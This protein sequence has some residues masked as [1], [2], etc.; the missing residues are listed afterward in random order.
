MALAGV[1]QVVLTVALIRL[2]TWLDVRSGYLLAGSGEEAMAYGLGT[3]IGALLGLVL[4]VLVTAGALLGSR[5][6]R[7]TFRPAPGA[8]RGDHPNAAAQAG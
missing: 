6:S 3:I 1:P 4:A 7:R 2:D 8:R 5:A